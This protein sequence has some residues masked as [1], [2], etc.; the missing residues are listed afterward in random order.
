[1]ADFNYLDALNNSNNIQYMAEQHDKAIQMTGRNTYI[2]PLDKTDT[3]LSDVYK[4][5]THGR[6]YLPHYMQK[7][8]YK[9]NT[10]ISQLTAANYTETENN[11]ELEYDLARMV[12]NIKG[13]KEKN[14]GMLTLT[15]I[16]TVPVFIEITDSLVVRNHAQVLFAKKIEGTVFKFIQEVNKETS[17][18]KLEYKGD[19]EELV[20]FD[21]LSTKV[22]PRRKLEINLNNSIYK[23]I[24]DVI[25]RGDIIVNDRMKAYQV[26]G[27]YPRNDS[28]TQYISWNI[29]AELINL[30]KIDGLP[31]DFTELLKSNQYGLGK[32]NI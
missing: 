15:N 28:Y 23:N 13:L 24:T 30:A 4:E 8:I 1:M 7:A 19:S 31:N 17:A 14:S 27:A 21:K 32:L 11:L 10:F 5:E 29:Q 20:F 6:V 16:S 26:V 9:T 25:S 12:S 18:I 22:L 3:S 2:F